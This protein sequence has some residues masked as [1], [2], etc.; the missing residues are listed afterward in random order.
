MATL[1]ESFLADLDDLDD[2]SDEEPAAA[3]AGAAAEAGAGAGG[4]GSGAGGGVLDYSNLEAVAKLTATAEYAELVGAVER[5][6]ADPGSV[7]QRVWKGA[8]EEDE[9]YQL[10]VRCNKLSVEMD[11]EMAVVH[12]F[13]KTKYKP[14]FP[15]LESLVHHPVDYARVIKKIGNE[16]DLTAVPLEGILPSATVMVVS[17]TA[18]T[19][20]GAQLPEAE[21]AKVLAASDMMLRIDADKRKVLQFVENQMGSIAPNLSAVLGPEIAAQLMGAAGGLVNLSKMPACNVQ[22]LGAKKRALAGFS[23]VTAQPH[24]GFIFQCDL[25]QGIPEAFRAKAARVVG[26]KCTLMARVDAYGT[27][28]AGSSGARM[29]EEVKGKMDKV[30]EAPPARIEKPLPVPDAEPK[31]RRGGRRYRKMKERYGMTE[32]RKA[33]NRVN[34]N[35]AEEEIMDGEETLGLGLVKQGGAGGGMGSRLRVEVKKQKQKISKNMQ[36]RLAQMKARNTPGAGVSGFS[37]SL[38]FTPV[39]GIELENP[40]ARAPK[41]EDTASGTQSYFSAFSGFAKAAKK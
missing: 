3:A 9:A 40:L 17:V 22:V 36:K 35:Q 5:A 37:S 13:L 41:Q 21:L 26:A 27:D 7:S 24:Q 8:A 19:T 16:M 30:M 38:A 23:A 2:L 39:Q 14:K 12:T 11:N 25:V 20:S 15:E 31:K 1:A 10:I 32:L 6:L 34:F 33:Q 28:P 29:K 18:S 4:G